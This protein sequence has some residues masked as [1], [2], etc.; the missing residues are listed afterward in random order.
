MKIFI[1]DFAD[2]PDFCF[3]LGD[4]AALREVYFR[5]R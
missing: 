4:F 2:G 3:F 5:R 1:K